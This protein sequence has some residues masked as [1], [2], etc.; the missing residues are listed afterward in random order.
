MSNQIIEALNVVLD[1][2][3][4]DEALSEALA[5]MAHPDE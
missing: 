2:D 5:A 4:P 3:L 1:W